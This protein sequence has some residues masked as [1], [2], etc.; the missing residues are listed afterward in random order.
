MNNKLYEIKYKIPQVYAIA[1]IAVQK[2]GHT[3]KFAKQIV[4]LIIKES[5]NFTDR[6]LAEFL[7]KDPI[8]KILGYIRKP[9]HSVFSKVRKRSDERIFQEIF[10]WLV[11][12]KMRGK[13]L[14]LIAQDSS[15]IP[16]Y[17]EKDKDARFGHRT[18]SKK[19]QIASKSIK[20][21]FVFGYKLH[22]IVDAETDMPIV[23]EIAPANKH[24]KTFFH[25]LYTTL[26]QRFGT[27]MNYDAKFLG[28][29]G[30]DSTDIYQELHYDNI[31]PVIAING[32]GHYKSEKPI[33]KEYG[34]RWAVERVFSRLKQLFGLAKNRF[35]GIKKVSMHI[36][37]CVIAYLMKY[38]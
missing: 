23:L 27:Q 29:A 14:R 19:E 32:R 20:K 25:S 38:C 4:A 8:G 31:K 15:D 3:K 13:Q 34:K 36:Y 11:Q 5:E 6:K 30:Y 1:R 33:D 35:I 21:S 28:D 24:D 18:P 12:N 9:N 26:K 17:S 7:E 22:V 10:E 37:S 2:Y 16:A